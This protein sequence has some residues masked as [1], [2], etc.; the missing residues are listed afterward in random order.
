MRTL[1][2]KWNIPPKWVTGSLSFIGQTEK[3]FS[4]TVF[5]PEKKITK[6]IINIDSSLLHGPCW[7]TKILTVGLGLMEI[8]SKLAVIEGKVVHNDEM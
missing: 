3:T 1:Q 6:M 5:F 7:T 2:E 4:K 8:G